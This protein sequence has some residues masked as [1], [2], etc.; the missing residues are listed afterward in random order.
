[1]HHIDLEQVIGQAQNIANVEVGLGEPAAP[2]RL[3]RAALV[4][5]SPPMNMFEQ[6]AADFDKMGST[7]K[8]G[9]STIQAAGE[10]NQPLTPK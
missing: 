1:M 8:A 3:T 9:Q 7:L 2:L 6:K 10:D 5:Q 4:N